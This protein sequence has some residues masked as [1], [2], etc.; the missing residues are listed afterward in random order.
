M[1]RTKSSML[2][3]L[4]SLGLLVGVTT[5]AQA[6]PQQS[7]DAEVAAEFAHELME[8]ATASGGDVTFDNVRVDV[9][10]HLIEEVGST[11]PTAIVEYILQE[12]EDVA[13][14]APALTPSEPRSARSSRAASSLSRRRSAQLMDRA[15]E[16]RSASTR[17]IASVPPADGR[18]TVA[19]PVSSRAG[20]NCRRVGSVREARYLWRELESLR[21][22]QRTVERGRCRS[23][24]ERNR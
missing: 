24:Q 20:D 7:L 23:S 1:N 3:G 18:G 15:T 14:G 22:T 19:R 13:D 21:E 5:P 6:D 16:G 12:A 8:I 4:A 9:S 11:A 2:A 10:Q 17:E